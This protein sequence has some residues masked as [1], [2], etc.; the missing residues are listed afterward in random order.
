MALKKKITLTETNGSYKTI[1]PKDQILEL[2][3]DKEKNLTAKKV[4]SR[5]I[6]ELSPKKED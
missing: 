4:G 3:W 2:G 1:L 5:I 6:I